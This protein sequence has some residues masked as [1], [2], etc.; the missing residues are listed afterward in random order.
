MVFVMLLEEPSESASGEEQRR[1]AAQLTAEVLECQTRSLGW[2]EDAGQMPARREEGKC[3][4][5]LSESE[6]QG[7]VGIRWIYA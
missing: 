7:G 6:G 5:H 2:E 1:A 4:Q 3:P